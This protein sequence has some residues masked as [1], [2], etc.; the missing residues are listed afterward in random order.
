MFRLSKS[1]DTLCCSGIRL[2]VC[3][4]LLATLATRMLLPAI[5]SASVK[6]LA[7]LIS[8]CLFGCTRTPYGPGYAQYPAVG[9]GV[10]PGPAFN[11]NAGPNSVYAQQQTNPQMLD[12]Q[13]RVTQLDENNRQ[14]T[15]QL[16]Q[17]QQQNQAFRERNDLLQKQL[18]DASS[19]YQQLLASNQQYSA[20]ARGLQASM[21]RRGG[22]RLTANNSLN[23]RASS[24]QIAGARVVPDGDLIRIRVSS[25][26]LFS[27]GTAQ[28]NSS[29]TAVLDQI[30]S[31]ITR[32]FSRQ[33]VGIEGHTDTT[34][35]YGASGYQVAGAQAQAVLD[36][37]T[38]RSGVPS[39]QLFVAA[40][41]PNHPVADNYS[42]A[43]RAENRRI[44]IVIYPETF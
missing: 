24:I 11:P 9:T 12:L 43:G 19:Q 7:L 2:T 25:D 34:Q 3:H 39:K 21:Q 36:L 6:W 33:R 20:Q 31:T 5:R 10:P 13:R 16:A 1:S 15:T 32:D 37:L 8:L 28:L 30:G 4:E 26:Q 29:G 17:Q 23:G 38:R 40:H 22:A 41:G 44:E 35:T 14:L 42:P 18:Q 27:P